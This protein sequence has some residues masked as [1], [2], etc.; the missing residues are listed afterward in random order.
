MTATTTPTGYLPTR[1]CACGH[2]FSIRPSMAMR[3][4][5]NSGHASCP[6]CSQF[7]HIEA[8][9]CEASTER[10]EDYLKRIIPVRGL[11]NT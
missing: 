8:L 11:E 10:W 6:K 1:C 3:S 2:E 5:I 4:G 7:L 9:E